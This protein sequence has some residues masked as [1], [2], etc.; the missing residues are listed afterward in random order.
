MKASTVTDT[1][2]K[3]EA[4]P[5]PLSVDWSSINYA[6]PTVMP[7][8][9]QFMLKP[10]LI[11]SGFYPDPS[12]VSGYDDIIL[13]INNISHISTILKVDAIILPSFQ[14]LNSFIQNNIKANS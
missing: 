10:Y 11:L 2:G 3:N 7:V 6:I 9:E 5:D 13:N 8:N 4:W 14:D 12:S 1:I